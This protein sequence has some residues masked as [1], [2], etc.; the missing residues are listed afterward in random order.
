MSKESSPYDRESRFLAEK[1]GKQMLCWLT[2]TVA[3]AVGPVS[4]LKTKLSVPGW[5]E[6]EGD[7]IW[8]T[9]RE[10]RGGAPWVVLV[11]FQTIPTALMFG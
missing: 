7:L 10:D 5:P 3:E 4:P 9:T 6:R 8:R 11:E 1:G 2:K